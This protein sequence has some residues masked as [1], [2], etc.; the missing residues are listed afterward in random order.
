[1]AICPITRGLI[2]AGCSIIR[3][4][5]DGGPLSFFRI[6]TRTRAKAG[7]YPWDDGEESR[8]MPLFTRAYRIRIHSQFRVTILLS[9][10][11]PIKDRLAIRH[12]LDFAVMA[13]RR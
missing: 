1:M 7:M 12:H 5:R 13:T 4:M 11:C 6:K 3:F 9:R 10:G 2:N 8:P